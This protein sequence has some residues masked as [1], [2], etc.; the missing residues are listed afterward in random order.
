MANK[1]IFRYGYDAE[2]M[3]PMNKDD[4]LV[5]RLNLLLVMAKAYLKSY[6]LGEFR[7]QAISENAQFIFMETIKRSRLTDTKDS[8]SL[9]PTDDKIIEKYHLF[10]QRT[11]LLA[12]MVNSFTKNKCKGDFR[13]K[14]LAENIKQVSA[15]LSNGFQ[16]GISETL[17]V[18]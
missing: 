17:Q 14:A 5:S 16:I 15:F 9:Q 8:F 3:R 4:I 18:A 10:W 12:I 1:H 13:K 2:K 6:P 7:R 11:Q